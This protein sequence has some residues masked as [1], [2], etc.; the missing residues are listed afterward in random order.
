MCPWR[1]AAAT[2]IQPPPS[3]HGTHLVG[4]GVGLQGLGRHHVCAVAEG[5]A[6]VERVGVRLEGDGR[7]C[8]CVRACVCVCV[9]V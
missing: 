8:V 7:V 2:S 9:C 1:Q 4:G 5:R 6:A 3:R